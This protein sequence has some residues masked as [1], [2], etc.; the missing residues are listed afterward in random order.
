[1]LNRRQEVLLPELC[2]LIGP[3]F[4][5]GLS[6]R[7]LLE[8]FLG[9]GDGD[10][11]AALVRRH[12]PTVLGV[13]RR[14]LHNV[15]DAEDAFQATFLVLAR[16]GRSI[17]RREALGS[18]LY[19]VAYRVALKARA[20]DARRRDHERRAAVRAEE[21]ATPAGTTN[22]LGPVLDEEIN[23][24]PDKYRRPIVLCYFEGKTYQEAARLL[25]C[26]AGTAS[27]R[28]ARARQLLRTRLARRG[29][30]PS[31]VAVAAWLAGAAAPAAEAG[32]LAEATADAAVRFA[33]DPVAAEISTRVI[34]LTEGVVQ[35]MLQRKLKTLAGVFVAVGLACAAWGTLW[36]FA[37]TGTAAADDRPAPAR[38]AAPAGG[39]VLA[40]ADRPGVDAGT[41]RPAA[42]DPPDPA[43]AGP[44]PGVLASPAGAGARPP[45]TR[46]GLINLTRV[47]KGANQFRSMQQDLRTQT[48]E[49]AKGLEVLRTKAGEYQAR[50]ADPATPAA[51]REQLE[52][53]V[54]RIRR[55]MEDEQVRAKKKIDRMQGDA[56]KLM[57]REVEDAADHIA[58]R[59]GLELVLFYNDAVTEADF[60]TT[61]NLQRK[62][63]QPGL[64]P[65]IAA[66]GMDITD[67]VIKVLNLA[68]AA[69]DR[70]R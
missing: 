33:A 11:F 24:L 28:L 22:D 6:D 53:E 25:G 40:A 15:H 56:L 49:V 30:A 69:P 64:V 37:G 39:E 47:F 29:L 27:V 62:L 5:G 19:G 26:P 42:D 60:Y 32:L 18:F 38:A 59:D 45:Q 54:R 43:P 36:R 14:V 23:R 50:C 34:A 48:D 4:G 13:C 55:E 57:Y 70:R 52:G 63:S 10:A 67:T 2:R 66:P 61:Q 8:R 68:H 16:R 9:R 3:Q 41:P 46:I 17:A 51:A 35:A 1:M 31:A 20:R 44:P 21:E 65:M 58:K 12:G 7:D